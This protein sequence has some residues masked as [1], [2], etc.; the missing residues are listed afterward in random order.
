M[1]KKIVIILGSEPEWGGEHKYAT[2]LMECVET[3]D[4]N[5]EYMA[6]CGNWH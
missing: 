5:V 1:S 2:T 4:S 3:S 6:V